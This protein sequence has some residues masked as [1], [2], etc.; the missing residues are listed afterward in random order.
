MSVLQIEQLRRQLRE[1]F[2][3]A[4]RPPVP[5]AESVVEPDSLTFAAGK[6]SEII[7]PRPSAGASLLLKSLLAEERDLPLALID[8][9]NSFDPA[10]YGNAPCRRLLWL[11]CPGLHEAFQCADLLLGD[12][13]LP[14]V[15]LDLHLSSARELRQ[16]PASLWHRLKSQARSSGAALA[17]LT[18]H[19][20]VPTPHCRRTLTGRFTLDHLESQPPELKLAQTT[21]QSLA[22]KA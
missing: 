5:P 15:L 20:L 8:A 12:G 2:P 7:A 6:L 22:G 21:P 10:S 14:L 3:A 16:T 4:H 19:A 13:N 9:R 18:P 17:A 1:K 11:R